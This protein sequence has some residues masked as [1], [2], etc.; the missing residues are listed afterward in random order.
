[1]PQTLLIT[2]ASGVIGSA[3]A[4]ALGQDPEF[5]ACSLMAPAREASKVETA[6]AKSWEGKALSIPSLDL[7][8][9]S[10]VQAFCRGSLWNARPLRGMALVAGLSL[11][12][13]IARAQEADWDASM[14]VNAR[15]SA[16]ILEAACR[17]GALCP[18]A[19]LLL[20][21]SQA[22]LR[23]NVGQVAYAASKGC[24]SDILAA[25]QRPIAG[26]GARLN[27]LFPP[28]VPSPMTAA[29]SP[30][31]RERLFSTRLMQD[32][33]PASTCAASA[34]FLL[35]QRSS[36]IHAATWHA[37]SRISG[38]PWEGA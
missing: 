31:A 13:S 23:G 7:G 12:A 11:D 36:Y 5:S 26:R 30:Q 18:G 10:Q 25:Y 1:M 19:S 34:C 27:L 17:P 24:L 33:D 14:Q 15:S 4:K 16:M 28:L 9:P 3:L 35:S 21:G 32:P 37:D 2:G 22:G 20:V 38:L 29:L 8:D 6:L